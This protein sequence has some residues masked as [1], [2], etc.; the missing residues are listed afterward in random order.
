MSNE[1]PDVFRIN[2]L[3]PN[4]STSEHIHAIKSKAMEL[5]RMFNKSPDSESTLPDCRE[6]ALAKTNLEQAVMWAVK[7]ITK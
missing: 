7:G 4:E 3:V 5:Y 6:I 1:L 2:D